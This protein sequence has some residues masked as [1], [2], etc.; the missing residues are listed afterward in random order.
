MTALEL[1]AS[2]ISNKEIADRLIVSEATVNT[3]VS[4]ILTKPDA[5]DRAQLVVVG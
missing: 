4:R 2:G 1:V 5:R 3:H